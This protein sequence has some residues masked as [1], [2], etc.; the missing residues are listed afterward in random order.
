MM[1]YSALSRHASEGGH[2]CDLAKMLKVESIVWTPAFAGVTV[3]GL[4]GSLVP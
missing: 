4:A 2:P 3:R 1:S